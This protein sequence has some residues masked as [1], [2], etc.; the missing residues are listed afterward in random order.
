MIT[1]DYCSFELSRLLKEKGLDTEFVFFYRTDE[2][3]KYIH[4]ANTLQP[5][6]YKIADDEVVAA[7]THQLAMKWLRMK[8]NI[9]IEIDAD[10]G[11]LGVKV[12]TPF[13]STYKSVTDNTNKLRQYKRGLHYKD[14][15][16]VVPALQHFSTHEEAVEAALKYCLT[17][18]I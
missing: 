12:Y 6:S 10:V 4:H 3:G 2:E 1:E 14:D 7:I 5:I 16:G 8:H 17:K 11:M 13:I 18:V 15:K 9:D